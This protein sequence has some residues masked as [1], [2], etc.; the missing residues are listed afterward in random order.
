MAVPQGL[1]TGST[2]TG[3]GRMWHEVLTRLADRCDLRPVGESRRSQGMR[4]PDVW[5]FDGHLG[6]LHVQQPQVVQLHEAPW[7]EPES[8]E[9]LDQHFLD[10]VVEPSRQAARAAA[11]VICPSASA[12]QQIVED[13]DIT[14]KKV[15][16]AHHGVDHAVFHP[17]LPDGREI[18]VRYG[19]D[20]AR[21]FVLSVA[22]VH[23]RKNLEALRQAVGQLAAEGLPHQLLMVGG[24]AHGRPD[25]EEL[26]RA[27]FEHLPAAPDRVVEIPFGI[28][29][30]QIAALMASADAFCLP[31][32]SEGFGLP[33][34][35]AMAC[36]APTVLSRRGALIEVGA[37]AAVMVD[38]TPEG[39]ANG[40]RPLL[41]DPV[42]RE[43]IGYACAIR[44]QAFSW[45]T[46]VTHWMEALTAAV[47]GR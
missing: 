10:V 31:S 39:I 32:L 4:P 35:E 24:P 6:P 46:C 9:T 26:H 44:A 38:P 17:G 28:D 42:Q 25:W 7:N 23:P 47:G 27:V 22:S 33:A 41:V 19:A 45:D 15:Y 21:P 43:A 30:H 1:F 3:R 14:A 13:S 5:L 40:L 29:D 18:A 36:G 34:A 16:V 11:A 2:A 37:D 8:M 12:K 20:A